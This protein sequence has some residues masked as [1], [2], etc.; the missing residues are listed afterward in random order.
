[1][2][3]INLTTKWNIEIT[4]HKVR[5]TI[6]R[7][8][9]ASDAFNIVHTEHLFAFRQICRLFL[10]YAMSNPAHDRTF[11]YSKSRCSR[12]SDASNHSLILFLLCF[13]FV[14]SCI[15]DDV[16]HSTSKLS[17]EVCRICMKCLS[18]FCIRFLSIS[19]LSRSPSISHFSMEQMTSS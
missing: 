18:S 17:D 5:N 11:S 1:M 12:P 7:C 3:N 14:A 2:E 4:W 16:E 19:V 10:R 6:Q 8:P 9:M 15:T 13:F